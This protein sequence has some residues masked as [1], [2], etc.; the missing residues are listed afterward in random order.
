MQTEAELKEYFGN[1]P[2]LEG[3]IHAIRVDLPH[4]ITKYSQ[5]LGIEVEESSVLSCVKKISLENG[6]DIFALFCSL[7]NFTIPVKKFM[8]PMLN[9]M[10][11]RLLQDDYRGNFLVFLKSPI[12][13]QKQ[14]LNKFKW[15]WV[16]KKGEIHRVEGWG[17]H[18]ILKLWDVIYILRV[19]RYIMITHDSLKSFAKA[20]YDNSETFLEFLSRFIQEFKGNPK[21]FGTGELP[22]KSCYKRH[23]LF[24]RWVCCPEPDLHIWTFIPPTELF[25][26]VDVSAQ[27]TLARLGACERE[28]RC[29]W[30][31][32]EDV[33]KFLQ[34]VDPQN[35]MS[36]DFWIS[37]LGLLRICN[38][39]KQESK[40][41]I[42]PL[43]IYCR[44]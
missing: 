37:R 12:Y 1:I 11:D 26:P 2:N 6:Q 34:L 27:R 31:I 41:E 38:S 4:F 14:V 33:S 5:E 17:Y 18:R 28:S 8:V 20:I 43:L 25:A 22:F 9:G 35:P 3:V 13:M 44:V 15:A 40:C 7:V 16:S 29:S 30:S 24:F 36:A 32:V 21:I 23:L 39:K 10:I 19:L 42:C